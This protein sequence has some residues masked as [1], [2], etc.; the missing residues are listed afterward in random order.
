MPFPCHHLESSVT[1]LL[2]FLRL[3][4]STRIDTS[5][6]LFPIVVFFLS[7]LGKGDFRIIAE[8]K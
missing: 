2:N 7:S 5:S 8:R 3:S 6:N 1:A 4:R